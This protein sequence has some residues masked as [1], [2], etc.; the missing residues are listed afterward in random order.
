MRTLKVQ[1]VMTR[2]VTAVREDTPYK[3][4]VSRLVNSEVSG[5]PV[6][7]PTGVVVGVVSEGDLLFNEGSA[8]K[9]ERWHDVLHPTEARKADARVARDLMSKP[10]VTIAP[11]TPVR[12]AAALLARYSYKRLP[13]VDA[14]GKLVGIVSRRDVLGAFLRADEDIAGEVKHEVLLRTMSIDP[15]EV[16]VDVTDGVVMLSGRLERKSHVTVVESLTHAVDGV[17]D[18]VNNL[19]F[20]IDDESLR[21]VDPVDGTQLRDLW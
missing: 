13:V 8:G 4:I 20:E 9:H 7:S 6:L 19:T 2:D 12:K 17:V 11:N 18:V 3:E 21:L 16:D 14:V 1:D 5:L 10:A 15:A